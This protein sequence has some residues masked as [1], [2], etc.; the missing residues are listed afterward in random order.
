MPT[1]NFYLKKA[2]EKSGRSLIYLQFKYQGHRLVHAFG[3]TIDAANWN[4]KKQRVKSNVQT[5][6][7]GKHSLNDLL[8][9]LEKECIRAYNSSLKEGIPAP[10]SIKARLVSFVNQNSDSPKEDGKFFLHLDRFI[11]N[12]IKHKGRDK[13]PN[14]LKT[15]RTLKGHLLEFEQ[16]TKSTLTF[17]SINLDFYYKYVSFLRSKE[18]SPNAV[19]KDI[20]ILKVIMGEAVDLGLTQNLQFRHKKFSVSRD[21]TD[22][23]YLTE[24]EIMHLYRFDFSGQPRLERVRDLFVFGCFVGLRFSD[25]SDIKPNHI[26]EI[27]GE[28]FIK[29]VTKKTRELVII[30]C[31]PVIK[32]IFSKYS[33]SPNKLPPAP[34]NQKFND[35]IKEVCEAAKME[36]A[37]RLSTNPDKPL[38]ECI[39]SHTARR[40]FATNYYLAGFPTLDLM[41]IT[42]HRTEKAFMKYIRMSKLD[43]AKRLS[44]HIKQNWSAKLL[45]VAS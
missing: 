16:K 44:A 32:E 17:D 29:M 42:G 39:T 14:T 21:E 19:S 2:E 25:Y 34:S 10:E 45:K 18:L 36:E 38:W 13:S 24:N 15:Y 33:S 6:A 11:N 3:Q 8:D 20:Q 43:T 30:P 1:V 40:S 5:T 37:G 31:N 28:L 4:A 12:E 27:D 9:N 23:V 7:D 26:V 22:A 35:Y 41:K